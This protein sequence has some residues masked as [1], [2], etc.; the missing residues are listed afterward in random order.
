MSEGSSLLHNVPEA[1]QGLLPG[2]RGVIEYKSFSTHLLS[3]N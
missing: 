3:L 1:N 2:Y